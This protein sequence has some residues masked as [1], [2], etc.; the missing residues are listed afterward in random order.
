MNGHQRQKDE[1]RQRIEEALFALIEEKDYI[2]IT[3]S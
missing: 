2:Q 1:S 3:V